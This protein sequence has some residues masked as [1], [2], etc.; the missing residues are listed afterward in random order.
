VTETT[1]QK[2]EKLARRYGLTQEETREFVAAYPAWEARQPP[3][4]D[5]DEWRDWVDGYG[6]FM[7][8]PAN[9]SQ[10]VLEN[11]PV[12]SVLVTPNSRQY[13]AVVEALTGGAEGQRDYLVALPSRETGSIEFYRRSRMTEEDKQAVLVGRYAQRTPEENMAW[14]TGMMARQAELRPELGED[15]TLGEVLEGYAQETPDSPASLS[16]KRREKGKE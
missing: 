14:L 1:R 16:A 6:K 5:D 4:A 10:Q 7:E 11:V 8:E 9:I 15:P 2:A 12:G 13:E 3:D